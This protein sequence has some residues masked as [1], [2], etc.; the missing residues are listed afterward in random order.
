MFP[1]QF[2]AEWA[3]LITVS[4]N[5]R[6]LLD[7][8]LDDQ[9]E[10]KLLI[11]GIRQP[12]H[13]HSDSVLERLVR[14]ALVIDHVIV[15]EGRLALDSRARRRSAGRVRAARSVWSASGVGLANVGESALGIA[16]TLVARTGAESRAIGITRT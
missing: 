2:P 13:F 5:R 3:V 14:E 7:D 8:D 9:R 15:G 11:G 4:K 6:R 12:G 16:R 1:D 10:R